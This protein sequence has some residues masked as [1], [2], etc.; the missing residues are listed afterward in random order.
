MINKFF[1]VIKNKSNIIYASLLILIIVSGLV[2]FIVGYNNDPRK[3]ENS[4]YVFDNDTSMPQ[5]LNGDWC[6]FW[7]ELLTASELHESYS[8]QKVPGMWNQYNLPDSSSPAAKG[9]ATYKMTV[10]NVEI[11]EEYSIRIPTVGTSGNVFIDDKLLASIG[12]VAKTKELYLPK[13]K[14]SY[15]DFVVQDTSFDI[16]VQVANFDYARGGLW[17]PLIIAKADN[18]LSFRLMKNGYE[19]VVLGV[20][21]IAI[22][23]AIILI[24]ADKHSKSSGFFFLA[25]LLVCLYHIT[26]GDKLIV[27]WIPN[28]SMRAIVRMQYIVLFLT[29]SIFVQIQTRFYI[30]KKIR[31]IV[32]FFMVHGLIISI[33]ILLTPV[34]FFTTI[35]Y[36]GNLQVCIVIII[37][38]YMLIK[39]ITLGDKEAYL[40]LVSVAILGVCVIHDFLYG[41]AMIP[42]K[43][44]EMIVLGFICIIL[45]MGLILI[46]NVHKMKEQARMADTY[47]QAY[48]NAQIKPHFIFNTL[49]T[50]ASLVDKDNKKA[51]HVILNISIFLRNII[52]RTNFDDVIPISKE[53]EIVKSYVAI[54]QIRFPN[55]EIIIDVDETN[56]IKLPPMTLQPLVEN[57]IKHG[58]CPKREGGYIKITLNELANL[59]IISVADNGIGIGKRTQ[60]KIKIKLKE[61]NNSQKG[62]QMQT[63]GVGLSNVNSRF[64]KVY[65]N[66][67]IIES[68][69]HV[70]TVIRLIIDK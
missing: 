19:Y 12:K 17:L 47:E 3:V 32:N 20:M 21:G 69:P 10:K 52:D 28:I 13:Y 51:E 68:I 57:A 34:S 15:K 6:F 22:I 63:G 36:Y 41:S 58:L 33:I 29:P 45:F 66:P 8:Y 35:T 37:C 7:N 27:D 46:N 31:S 18:M 23:I 54:E 70:G 40:L 49:N 16:I 5:F 9:F 53:I 30:S 62:M 65:K 38:F 61:D 60:E 42:S 56:D 67:I 26:S 1:I 11:G 39:A 43:I 24:L 48:L 14:V 64:V 2:M 25:V 4:I 44:G 59:Y 55:I 50:L